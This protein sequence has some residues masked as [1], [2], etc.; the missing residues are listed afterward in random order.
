MQ[1]DKRSKRESEIPVR[2]NKLDIKHVARSEN[3]KYGKASYKDWLDDLMNAVGALGPNDSRAIV[4][5]IDED[6][7]TKRNKRKSSDGKFKDGVM[8]FES[9]QT[10]GL[11][12]IESVQFKDEI[13]S[14]FG[15]VIKQ[16]S[17]PLFAHDL[18]D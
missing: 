1:D 6:N 11:E 13:E 4:R 14:E 3:F 2:G 18:I 9:G 12:H 15:N 8:S 16:N 10:G 5:M 17:E 7:R